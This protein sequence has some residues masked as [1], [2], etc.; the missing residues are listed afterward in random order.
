MHLLMDSEFT[1]KLCAAKSKDEFLDIIEERE[2]IRYPAFK[3]DKK[4]DC[5]R[6][7][8]NEGKR[9]SKKL[10]FLHRNKSKN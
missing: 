2:K 5:S 6:L 7:I 4:Y 10:F 3:P 8:Q 9:S 1:A